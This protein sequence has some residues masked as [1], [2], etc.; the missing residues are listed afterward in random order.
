MKE[1]LHEYYC[2][3]LLQSFE[4]S[5]SLHPYQYDY[6]YPQ[7]SWLVPELTST[8]NPELTL[9]TGLDALSHAME[10]YWSNASNSYTRVLARDSIKIITNFLHV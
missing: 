5:T 7:E 9:A 10:S 4:T 6:L 8:L 3:L 2:L 1:L